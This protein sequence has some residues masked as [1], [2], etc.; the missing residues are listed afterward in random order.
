[1]ST[2]LL[3]WMKWSHIDKDD[4]LDKDE[5]GSAQILFE[6]GTHAFIQMLLS[7]YDTVEICMN[8]D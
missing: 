5:Y 8:S 7:Q 3:F 2:I 1:M 6:D 4:H